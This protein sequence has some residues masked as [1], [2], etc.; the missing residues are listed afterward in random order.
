MNAKQFKASFLLFILSGF[1]AIL[2]AQSSASGKNGMVATAHPLASE[3]AIE[4][5]KAG[6][7]AV[8]AAIAAAFAIGVVE[9]DGSGIGG[10]GGM[11]VYMKD[12]NESF[13]INY[14]ARGSERGSESGYSGSK[15]AKTA[16]AI[17]VPGTVAGLTLAHEKFGT[18]P[19]AKILEPAIRYAS[20]GFEVDATLALLI[21][22][23]IE[24]VMADSTT[25]NVFLVD[26]FPAMEGDR[27]IQ[28]EL[29]ETLKIIAKEGKK[30]FYE[31]DLTKAMVEGIADRGGVL[32][33]NDFASYEAE[34]T[35]PLFGN[36][37]GYEILT[38]NAPQS[39]VCLIEALNILENYDLRNSPHYSESAQVLHVM[40]ETER[41]VYADRTAYLGDPADADLPINGLMSKE[42]AKQ[43]FGQIDQKKLNPPVYTDVVEG[44]PFPFNNQSKN[45]DSADEESLTDGHTTH[46]SVIDKD[47]NSVA[48]TQTLGLFFGSGQMVN[49][50]LYNCAMTNFS[51]RESSINCFKDGKQSRSSIMPT[52]ILKDGNPYLIAGSP[53][54]ARII[55]TLI[56][57]II[58]VL[59][60]EMTVEE[61]NLAPRFFVRDSEDFLFM[62]SGIQNDVRK[63]LENMGHTLNV[64]NGIDLF[65]GGVQLIS[66][67]PQTNIYYGSADPRRGGKAIGY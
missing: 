55:T 54:A 63:E 57:V 59:D 15:D 40:A 33:L 8:D 37:H 29:A 20:E 48:L 4:M 64:I 41:F 17:C 49:G 26:E 24:T 39:G 16:K 1:L 34:L 2:S 13:Y 38:A 30:G 5:L 60:Y 47:G 44:D 61:A 65:F 58:N 32:T 43:R 35:K 11:V 66:V 21:L 50:V 3:A 42:Y 36:Y 46:L 18:L 62:E 25:S 67:D 9:P 28:K 23:N 56:E 19:L 7:N 52:I 45:T 27:I 51:F 6:G 53:G 10:G 31:S 22:D 12:R 14:Y